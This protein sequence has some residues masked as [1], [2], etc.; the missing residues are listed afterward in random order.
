MKTNIRLILTSCLGA[1]I[2][3]FVL[4][5]VGWLLVWMFTPG[6]KKVE[7]GSIL[8]VDLSQTV[9]ERTN[10]IEM[11]PFKLE[12]KKRWGTQE[13]CYA[14]R[15]AAE[16][17]K[18]VGIYLNS[19][20][21]HAS[22]VQLRDFRM[23]LQDFKKSGKFV[24]SY[25]N[26]YTEL[27]YY[28]NSVSDSI[29]LAETGL[30]DFR[31][32][33]AV[34]PFFKDAMDALQIKSKIFYAG[35]YKS[36]TEPFRR[37]EMS[38]QNKEQLHAYLNDI[39]A[40]HLREIS[41]SRGIPVDSLRKLAAHNVGWDAHQAQLH[42]M[43]DVLGYETEVFRDIRHRLGYDEDKKL[44]F[45]DLND[46]R[47][48]IKSKKYGRGAKDKIALVYAEGNIT[49]T[50]E[51]KPG[52]IT[53]KKYVEMLRKIRKDKKVKA[54][55]LRINSPGGNGLTSDKILHELD[56]A[57]Q[58]GIKVVV[59]MGTYAAS[60]GYYIACHADSIFAEPNTLTGSIGVFGMMFNLKG[61]SNQILKV[62]W[63]SVKTNAMAGGFSGVFDWSKEEDQTLQGMIDRFYEQFLGV[64]AKGRN[65][66]R[67]EVHA[68]AQGRIWTGERAV[69]NGLVDRIG[70]FDDALMSAKQLAGIDKFK[71]VVYPKIKDPIQKFIEDLT[72]EKPSISTIIQSEIEDFMPLFEV[73]REVQTTHAP[74]AR[75][76]M[77]IRWN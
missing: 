70:T 55:L 40:I 18:I 2:A 76:P 12:N 74:M 43:V 44:H 31:G 52:E 27:G 64:V 16:D 65:M 11:N 67:D 33:A 63:D 9:P 47:S 17:N 35:Q 60:G 37:N 68:I 42:R 46:Y 3:F 20:A 26:G 7:P 10:N 45:L 71:L 32:F 38:E 14:I 8:R 19:P 49:G 21:P 29:Y 5:L 22:A 57:Q 34:L 41:T 54:I 69:K 72:G 24:Y 13:L 56:L 50:S 62:H 28:L 25:G 77:D 1:I 73:L 36:A 51:D 59:S 66:T 61:L 39:Y 15:H 48:R 23:A 53:E 58:A 75:L 6:P 4:I 30:L